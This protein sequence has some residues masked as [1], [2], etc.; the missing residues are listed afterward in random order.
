MAYNENLT[1]FYN[2]LFDPDS[3]GRIKYMVRFPA[4]LAKLAS[5][6]ES[7]DFKTYELE[8]QVAEQL[9][10]ESIGKWWVTVTSS[11]ADSQGGWNIWR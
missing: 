7:E 9:G 2:P 11:E 6:Q 3:V 4:S 5:L 10:A 1:D 8:S